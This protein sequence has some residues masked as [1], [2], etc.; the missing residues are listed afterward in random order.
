MGI[1][2]IWGTWMAEFR[3]ALLGRTA[4]ASRKD[5]KSN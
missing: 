3:R 5:A 4:T 2:E 1:I